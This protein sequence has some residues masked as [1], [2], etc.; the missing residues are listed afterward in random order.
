L[1]AGSDGGGAER[2]QSRGHRVRGGVSV[3]GELPILAPLDATTLGE[4]ARAH[5]DTGGELLEHF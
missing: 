4:W 1:I 5:L 2:G 3:V